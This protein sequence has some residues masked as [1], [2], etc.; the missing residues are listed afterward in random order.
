MELPVP[1]LRPISRRARALRSVLALALVYGNVAVLNAQFAVVYEWVP[2][3]PVIDLLAD[4]FYLFGM[5][6]DYE[7]DAR[8]LVVEGY[9]AGA[10]EWIRLDGADFFPGSVA[11]RQIW[12]QGRR[13]LGEL[14][15]DEMMEDEQRC[16]LS[17]IRA[18]HNRLHP[19]RQIEK[20]RVG[21]LS[22][23]KSAQGHEAKRVRSEEEMVIWYEE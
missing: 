18:R 9:V 13:K 8:E 7:R 11:D 2:A 20:V 17:R 23:E 1:A 12:A 3:L 15:T 4:P 22:W 16:L 19:E 10:H 5:F 6:D 21:H 14:L